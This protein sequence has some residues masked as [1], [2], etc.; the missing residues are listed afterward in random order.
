MS[1]P[2]PEAGVRAPDLSSRI[3]LLEERLDEVERRL[4]VE[5]AGA[6]AVR[7]ADPDDRDLALPPLMDNPAATMVLVDPT[8]SFRNRIGCC[9]VSEPIR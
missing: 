9:V 7:A 8:G 2:L 1:F 4:G 6:A 3:R 5:R